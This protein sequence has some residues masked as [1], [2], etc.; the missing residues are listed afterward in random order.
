LSPNVASG[1]TGH[2]APLN[3]R[4]LAEAREA[5]VAEVAAQATLDLARER[6]AEAVRQLHLAGASM[7]EIGR[8]LGLSRERV[9]HL[10]D[11]DPSDRSRALRCSFCQADRTQTRKVIAGPAVYVCEACV[12]VADRALGGDLA[13]EEE[14]AARRTAA[15]PGRAGD[16]ERS[17]CS[18]CGKAPEQVAGMVASFGVRICRECLDLCLDI[19]EEERRAT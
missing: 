4:L 6:L 5:H 16:D 8:A 7:S 13:A 18:F 10:V 14:W 3:E 9:D 11:G 19:I 15:P 17:S 2:M 1:T 12:L